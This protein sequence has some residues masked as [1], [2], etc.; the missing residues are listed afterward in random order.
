MQLKSSWSFHPLFQPQCVCSSQLFH[1][2]ASDS[3]RTEL[4]SD[5]G[6]IH[7]SQMRTMVGKVDVG[8]KH[9]SSRD[10]SARI[11]EIK[12]SLEEIIATLDLKKAEI[13]QMLEHLTAAHK[14]MEKACILISGNE[15][16]Q[17]NLNIPPKR[18]QSVTMIERSLCFHQ[19]QAQ[20]RSTTCSTSELGSR[21]RTPARRQL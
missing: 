7:P 9:I 3:E 16:T 14:A 19:W 21:C 5:C 12:S 11:S 20:R 1:L 8:R 2:K 4:M 17:Q 15:Q 13:H 18:K 10:Q 6:H